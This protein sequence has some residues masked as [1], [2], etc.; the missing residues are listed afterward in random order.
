V[1]LIKYICATLK[2]EKSESY[3]FPLSKDTLWFVCDNRLPSL[4]N[5]YSVHM[6]WLFESML[7]KWKN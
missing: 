1:N 7:L 2:T 6:T 3:S 4:N 5:L